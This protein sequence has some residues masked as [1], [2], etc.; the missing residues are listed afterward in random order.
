MKN[1]YQNQHFTNSK[2]AASL[3]IFMLLLFLAIPNLMKGGTI[4]GIFT[5]LPDC[6]ESLNAMCVDPATGFLY[7]L[8]NASSSAYYKYNVSSG[9]WTALTSAPHS[10]GN[11][12]GATLLNGKIYISYTGYADLAVYTIATDSW[13]GRQCFRRKLMQPMPGT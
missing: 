12:A 9:T 10:T 1:I 11:N 4:T 6:P 5:T 3:T 2:P 13:T 7:A 8:G